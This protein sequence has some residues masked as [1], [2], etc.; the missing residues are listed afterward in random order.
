MKT[1]TELSQT[2]DQRPDRLINK[3]LSGILKYG[4]YSFFVLIIIFFALSSPRFFTLGNLLLILQQASPLGIAV[5][6]MTLVL[7]LAGIDISVGRNMFLSATV[8]AYLINKTTLLNPEIIGLSTA[9]ILVFIIAIATGAFIG[10]IN[11]VLISKTKKI[12]VIMLTAEIEESRELFALDV[13]ADDYVR[14][15]F[16][17][18]I[19]LAR[20]NA[21][22]RRSNT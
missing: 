11:G 2:I 12:P 18:T 4:V 3:L 20:V 10:L 5:V 15:P 13:G 8:I 7:I 9:Y 14:K 22:I 21:V 16:N 1:S 6:G 17:P 19:F